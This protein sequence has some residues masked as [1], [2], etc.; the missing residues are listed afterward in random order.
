MTES[1]HHFNSQRVNDRAADEF[2]GI[3]R[4]IL[5]DGSVTT[6]E[7]ANLFL[8]LNKHPMIAEGWLGRDIYEYLLQALEDG[9]ID[10]E[11]ENKLLDHLIKITGR[12]DALTL[13]NSLNRPLSGSATLPLCPEPPAEIIINGYGFVLTGKFSLG[14]RDEVKKLITEN[15]GKAS[16]TPS[17][18]VRYLVIGDIGS[19][20]WIHSS[21]GRKIER[22]VELREQGHQISIITEAHFIKC[23]GIDN[24]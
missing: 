22:A 14:T 6:D 12:P 21:Y 24:E 11:E 5:F 9:I 13:D 16:G 20:D 18:K 8:W 1:T 15:G 23:I 2:I 4:G 17:K 19:S 10:S 3:C 7:A